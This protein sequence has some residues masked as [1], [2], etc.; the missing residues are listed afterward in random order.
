MEHKC[1][2][3]GSIIKYGLFCN[4]CLERIEPFKKIWDKSAFYYNKGLEAAKRKELSLACTFLQK[5]I[6][7]Y[8]YNIDARNLLGLI[9]FETG[10]LGDALKEWIMSQFL[11]REDNL[12]TIYIERVHKEPKY[13]A[14]NREAINLYNKSLSYLKQKDIDMALIRLKKA[15][16]MQPN[17]V[18]ARALLAL[19]YIEQKQYHKAN[20]QVKKVL[21]IDEGHKKALMYSKIL[22]GE[23][24]ETIEPYDIEY[25]PKVISETNIHKM[26][27]RGAMHRRAVLYFALGVLSVVII[28]KY[29]ILPNEVNGYKLESKRLTE[30]RDE[31]S[32]QLM[33]TTND[34]EAK[35]QALE[36]EKSKFENEIEDYKTQVTAIS[37]K[38]KLSSA[39]N[40]FREREYVEAA[41]AIYSIAMS[42]LE[43]EDL[44]AYNELKE[45][46]Y[47]KAVDVLYNEGISSYN[48]GDYIQAITPFETLLIY[49]PKERQ[50]R[51]SL[52]YL[53][54][55]YE[56]TE[57]IDM[58]KKYYNQVIATYPDTTEYYNAQSHLDDISEI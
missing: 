19:V 39:K 28:G 40:L 13:L 49:E 4:V 8:R 22:S 6:A 7:L 36:D 55:S 51:K 43:G 37:Q 1:P 48:R 3:C 23:N 41:K 47:P 38:E 24:T 42:S 11:Q 26:L 18:E 32:R 15:V 46:V 31:L 44:E 9:Y 35:L 27:D 30:E 58:A 29:L 10:Q 16:A 12:A 54:R 5:A 21:A 52:Y 33:V 50:A 34:Y 45:E 53:G 57:N 2:Y 56:K 25:K 17:F 20:E 14:T